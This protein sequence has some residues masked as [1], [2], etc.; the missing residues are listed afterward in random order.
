MTLLSSLPPAAACTLQDGEVEGPSYI[1]SGK[2]RKCHGDQH[3]TWKKTAMASAFAIL[4]PGERI[5]EKREAGLDPDKDYTKDEQCLPCH[6]T[7]WGL[8]GGYS[9]PPEGKTPA[10]RKA[11]KAAKAMEGVQCEACH[12]P[13]SVTAEFKKDNQKYKWGEVEA[14]AGTLSGMLYPAEEMCTGCHNE[15]SPFVD[16]DYVFEFEQRREEGTHD[17]YK[18]EF[19]HDCSHSHAVSKKKKKD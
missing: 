1:G 5:E 15:E 14:S 3:K 12:G 8:P 7:G 2:C 16:E 19:E 17:H 11:Q 9:I 6:V 13:A 18:M 10:A 4:K